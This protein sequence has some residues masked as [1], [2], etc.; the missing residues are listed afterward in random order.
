MTIFSGFSLD[1]QQVHG[2]VTFDKE[3]IY[4][5]K[6]MEVKYFNNEEKNTFG[7][8]WG[9][10]GLDENKVESEYLFTQSLADKTEKQINHAMSVAAHICLTL[11]D[12]SKGFLQVVS[13]ATDAKNLVEGLNKF[14]EDVI[15]QKSFYIKISRSTYQNK[16]RYGFNQ[17]NKPFISL[18]KNRLKL[19]AADMEV[20]DTTSVP[21]SGYTPPSTPPN[22]GAE[23]DLPF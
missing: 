4:H 15:G 3:G 13:K 5:A 14:L 19:T 12:D 17:V 6:L 2:K 22:N 21:G 10:K 9:F 11:K 20:L 23:D 16:Y 8:Q 7:I 1:D 18:D